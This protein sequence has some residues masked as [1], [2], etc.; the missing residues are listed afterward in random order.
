[1]IFLPY[2]WSGGGGPPGNRYFLSLY[3]A[4]FFLMPPVS[5]S[6][7][8]LLAWIGGALFTAKILVNPFVS[9]KITWEIA[10]RGA[11]RRLPVELTMANDLPVMLAQPLRG[12]IPYGHDPT[13]LLYFLDRHAFPPEPSGMWIAGDGRA[14][15]IVRSED[16]IHHL[17]I[18]AES[19]IET[20]LTI[21]A[22]AG[23]SRLP[24][25]PGKSVAF[26]VPASG[27]RGLNSYAYLLSAQSSD[28][29][30]PHLRDRRSA[31]NRNLGV[32]INFKA[33]DR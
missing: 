7:P 16:P 11:A 28:G 14:D 1:L 15:V 10:E 2:T 22:G 30:T 33:M 27:V 25:V 5:S 19:P 21:S 26:D 29:F 3:P 6:S 32:L 9:A 23:T 20:I 12:H 4:L 13:V 8:A 18:T 17:A 31:D 24:I